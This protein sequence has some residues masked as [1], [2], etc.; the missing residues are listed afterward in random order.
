MIAKTFLSFF[1]SIGFCIALAQSPIPAIIPQPQQLSVLKGNFTFSGATQIIEPPKALMAAHQELMQ[2]AAGLPASGPKNQI[3]FVVDKKILSAEG[4]RLNVAPN[5]IEIAVSEL[6]GAFWAVSSLRQLI[7]QQNPQAKSKKSVIKIPAVQIIDEP[8]F[9]WRGLHLDVARHFFDLPYLE[10]LIDRM[11]FYKLNKFHFHLTDDQGWRIEIKKY[12]QLT[13]KGAW[14]TFNRHDTVCMDL[15]KTNPDFALPQKHIKMV[16]GQKMYGGFYTQ[17]QIRRL[18]SYA[19]DKG[20]EIIPEIDMPGHMMIATQLMPW[21]T[22]KGSAGFGKSFS[23]PLCPCKETSF[24]FA[25]NVMAEIAALFPSK[26]IHLGADEVEKDSWK[27]LPE[28]ADLMKREGLASVEE[29]QSYFV[30]RMEKFF[31]AKGKKLIGWDEILEGG[32]S[33]TATIMYWRGWVKDAPKK[34][35]ANGNNIIMTPTGYC[36]FDAKQDDETVKI[37][38]GF[39]PLYFAPS[40]SDVPKVL[41]VQGNVWTEYIPSENRLEYMVFPRLLALAEVGWGKPSNNWAQFDDRLKVHHKIMDAMKIRYR[42]PDISG[43]VE[44]SVFIDSAILKVV[45]PNDGMV[46]RY[47]TDGTVPTLSSPVLPPSLTVKNSTSFKLAGFNAN[48]NRGDIH[49]V[50]YEQQTY[51]KADV[52]SNLAPALAYSYYVGNYKSVSQLAD[53]DLADTGFVSTVA[54]P[55]QQAA[56]AFGLK[57]KGY[58]YAPVDGVYGFALRSDDGSQ[59]SLGG[60]LLVDNDGLHSSQV[61]TAQVALEKGYHPIEIRFIEGGGGYSLKLECQPPNGMFSEISSAQLFH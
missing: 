39:D 53:K 40:A 59:M 3:V 27:T 43:F 41:G 38:Y 61:K 35:M 26:Y 9:A 21:L 47:T 24:E 16:N 20:I 57:L 5:K 48:G 49:A 23:E 29:L 2:Q 10:K 6:P 32:A 22:A 52:V 8:K 51:R 36:Y 7:A 4:Y 15:A 28:C 1:L 33:S 19:A 17:E 46:V 54:I 58:F 14:R 11:A 30:R 13:Q 31:H 12:P 37:L 55:M 60:R 34:S 45:K 56:P 18:I 25:E 44:K 42:I 50:T